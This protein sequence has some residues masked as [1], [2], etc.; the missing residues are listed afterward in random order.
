MIN[1]IQN[2]WQEIGYSPSEVEL[3]DDINEDLENEAA[4]DQQDGGV[5]TPLK[6][7][8]DN[9][10]KF[11]GV[12]I[13]TFPKDTDHGVIVDFLVKAG[14]GAENTDNMVIKDNGTVYI[15]D[16]DNAACKAVIEN[17]HNRVNFGRKLYCNGI[18]P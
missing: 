12:R 4:I 13:K 10:E 18:I 2:L 9:S 1:Y 16:L 6:A 11:G 8:T 14:L 3:S 15:R 17:I 5:F 7:F